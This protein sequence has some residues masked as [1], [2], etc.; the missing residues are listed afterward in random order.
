MSCGS[1]LRWW[2]GLMLV[3]ALLWVPILKIA[4]PKGE[5]ANPMVTDRYRPA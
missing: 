5:E 2:L 1:R 4:K 3:L